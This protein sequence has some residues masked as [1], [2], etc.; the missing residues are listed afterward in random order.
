VST[1]QHRDSS[2]KVVHG[3]IQQRPKSVNSYIRQLHCFIPN[4]NGSKKAS[5]FPVSARLESGHTAQQIKPYRS[6]TATSK[7]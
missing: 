3:G 6:F 4:F 7:R 1:V 5:K 2:R